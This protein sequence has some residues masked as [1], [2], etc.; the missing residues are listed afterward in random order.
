MIQNLLAICQSTYLEVFKI[1]NQ[2]KLFLGF[3]PW[4]N[5][6]NAN[7]KEKAKL[8]GVLKQKTTVE[9]LCIELPPE[10][11]EY[12]YYLKTLKFQDTPDYGHLI[13]LFEKVALSHGFKN[14]KRLD[15]IETNNL[16]TTKVQTNDFS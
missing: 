14:D 4:Q 15:W 5:V 1:A 6:N 2:K 16:T 7:E 3:L 12:F 8:V 9:E 10:F 13:S 11:R